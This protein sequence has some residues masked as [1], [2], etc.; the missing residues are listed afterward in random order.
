MKPGKPNASP[1]T[2]TL[3]MGKPSVGSWVAYGLG[4][5]NQNMPAFL[6]LPDPGGGIKGG[7]PAWGSGFLPATYQGTTLRPGAS[8]LLHLQPPDE[9]GLTRQQKA[10][11]LTRAMNERHLAERD[12]DGEL[13]ARINAYELAFRMQSSAPELVDQIVGE[14]RPDLVVVGLGRLGALHRHLFHQRGVERHWLRREVAAEERVA[15]ADELERRCWRA[16]VREA[17]MLAGVEDH[18]QL[19]AG[20]PQLRSF[21]FVPPVHPAR[22][23][24][25]PH[26]ASE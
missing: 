21:L 23:A 22:A 6:V 2:G 4:S 15:I 16:A 13:A 19:L 1:L 8:P 11:A 17:V 18:I 9:V 10:L 24:V 12:H 7:P 25:R 3:S 20:A 26:A 5:E 14:E